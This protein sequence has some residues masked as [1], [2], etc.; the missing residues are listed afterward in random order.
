MVELRGAERAGGSAACAASCTPAREGG[1]SGDDGGGLASSSTETQRLQG[2]LVRSRR[3]LDVAD[4]GAHHEVVAWIEER[5]RIHVVRTSRLTCDD[6]LYQL[7]FGRADAGS[8]SLVT[9][10]L[11]GELFVD[12]GASCVRCGPGQGIYLPTK[13][14][15]LVRTE[16]E[17]YEALVLEWDAHERAPQQTLTHDP[18]I[19]QPLANLLVG[20]PKPEPHTFAALL[21]AVDE[22]APA[23]LVR[24]SG[25]R[26]AAPKTLRAQEIADALDA[27]LSSLDTHPMATDL[28][29]RLG[30]SG[31]Q[32][33][34]MVE[35][36]RE[37]YGYGALN[38]LDARNRR[39]LMLAATLLTAEGAR[40]AEVARA[41]GYQ[42]PET[43][44]RAF[45]T[46]GLPKPRNVRGYVEGLG[47]EWRAK[48]ANAS[49]STA[50]A[51]WG[52]A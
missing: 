31:R 30:V 43:M 49:P 37:R 12:T 14:E 29:E 26:T 51:V 8:R 34:R 15:L 23:R 18:R 6:R 47:A 5:M 35:A 20:A 42:R 25:P 48:S 9:L 10:V 39:R 21:R 33:T 13:G 2:T 50:H 46:A 24:P 27:V 41:V 36:F 11:S 17:R 52:R 1:A 40:V 28:E 22:V 7:A 32:V 3:M 44:A 19:T 16:G 4:L 45:A 38:W